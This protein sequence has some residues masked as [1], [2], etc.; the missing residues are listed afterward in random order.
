MIVNLKRRY[1]LK[2]KRKARASTIVRI[3]VIRQRVRLEMKKQS[4]EKEEVKAEHQEEAEK[5][6]VWWRNS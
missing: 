1:I 3:N 5:E 4:D 6:D 2:K